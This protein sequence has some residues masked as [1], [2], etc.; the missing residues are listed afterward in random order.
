MNKKQIASHV[1]AMMWASGVEPVMGDDYFGTAEG[2][3]MYNLIIGIN[4]FFGFQDGIR[5]NL[6]AISHT[7]SPSELIAHVQERSEH[8]NR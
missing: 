5:L 7:D 8:I 4:N 2:T 1:E 3:R 6:S